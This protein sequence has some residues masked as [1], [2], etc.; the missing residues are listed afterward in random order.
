MLTVAGD[1]SDAPSQKVAWT[2]LARFT[3]HFGK[4]QAQFDI[5][6][7]ERVAAELPPEE[8]HAIPG[9]ETFI[10]ERLIPLAFEVPNQPGYNIKDGQAFVVSIF[11]ENVL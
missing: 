7:A 6:A 11:S 8:F 1:P 9:Y 4:T 2:L 5:T 10:Y 3:T